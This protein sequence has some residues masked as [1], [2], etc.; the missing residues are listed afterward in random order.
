MLLIG[1]LVLG[2]EVVVILPAYI[3]CWSLHSFEGRLCFLAPI[4]E[5]H[6]LNRLLVIDWWLLSLDFVHSLVHSN[7]GARQQCWRGG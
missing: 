2:N 7:F 3:S 4:I 6:L 1:V 5:I